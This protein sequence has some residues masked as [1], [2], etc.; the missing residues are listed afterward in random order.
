MRKQTK[1]SLTRKLDKECSRIVRGRGFCAM[2]NTEEYEKLQCAHIYS[3][4][5]RSVRWDLDNLLALCASCHFNSHRNPLNFSDFVKTHL[6]QPLCQSLKIR[7]NTPKR[8]ILCEMQELL[9]ILEA[10]RNPNPN[11]RPT[12]K[13]YFGT[14]QTY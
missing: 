12:N 6:G 5:Y 10:L 13:K 14:P 1:S 11:T 9:T 7:A 8:W 3:R 2:C 4:V